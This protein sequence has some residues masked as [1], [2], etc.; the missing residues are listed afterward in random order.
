MCS[1]LIFPI[2][3]KFAAALNYSTSTHKILFLILWRGSK[4]TINWTFVE[5]M[6]NYLLKT[7]LNR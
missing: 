3:I 4:F 7:E 2:F 1:T 6:N 5:R